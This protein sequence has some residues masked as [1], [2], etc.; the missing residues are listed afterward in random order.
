MSRFKYTLII[1]VLVVV[2]AGLRWHPV[3]IRFEQFKGADLIGQLTPLFLAALLIERSLEVFISTWRGEEEAKKQATL[4]RSKKLSGADP[5]NGNNLTALK[6]AENDLVEYKASTQ[7]IAMP[8]ALILG[9]LVSAL[10]V[11]CL[12]NLVVADAFKD[13]PT[14]QGWFTVAD[15]LLTG[16][17]VGGGSDFVHQFITSLT[18]FMNK[19][20]S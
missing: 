20:A 3:A 14:Q 9:I 4:D 18:D 2:I 13:H 16:G 11:R 19:P 17:P 5:T 12:G 6:D 8:A 1:V 15:V 10:G 7:Q